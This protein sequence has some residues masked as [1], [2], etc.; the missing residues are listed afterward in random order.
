MANPQVIAKTNWGMGNTRFDK[1][2]NPMKG[3]AM[4][5]KINVR[6]LK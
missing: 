1:G 5:H 6:G 4:I 3:M 2:Y